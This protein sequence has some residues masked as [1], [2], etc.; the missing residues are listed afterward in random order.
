MREME[1]PKNQC[2]ACRA[3]N[4]PDIA[5]CT[6]CGT[7][8]PRFDEKRFIEESGK[9]LL[10]YRKEECLNYHR[11]QR[12]LGMIEGL[13]YCQFCGFDLKTKEE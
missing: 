7:K 4:P 3:Y 5:F 12:E 9:S 11:N 10:A 13:R 6:A 2:P 8:N 1:D